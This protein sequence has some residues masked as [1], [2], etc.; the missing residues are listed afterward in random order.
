[1]TGPLK[2]PEGWFEGPDGDSAL[3]RAHAY[4]VA[5]QREGEEVFGPAYLLEA[6]A[7]I[8]RLRERPALDREALVQAISQAAGGYPK[9]TRPIQDAADAVMDLLYPPTH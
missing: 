5:W 7:A 4:G 6:V 8:R 1:M 9:A 3:D 2:I